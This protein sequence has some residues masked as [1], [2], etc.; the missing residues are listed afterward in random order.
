MNYKNLNFPIFSDRARDQ[1]E[2]DKVRWRE[3]D[4]RTC[5]YAEISYALCFQTAENIYIFL[6]TWLDPPSLRHECLSSH[7]SGRHCG[8]CRWSCTVAS[9]TAPCCV[10][11][12]W[13]L[14]RSTWLLDDTGPPWQRPAGGR[15]PPHYPDP[16]GRNTHYPMYSFTL[17]TFIKSQVYCSSPAQNQSS[18]KSPDKLNQLWLRR[19]TIDWTNECKSAHTMT[20][21]MPQAYIIQGPYTSGHLK[22]KAIQDFSRL[23]EKEIQDCFNNICTFKCSKWS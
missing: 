16:G 14:E 7:L 22:S 11:S 21:I 1:T 6:V 8:C 3:T 9:T 17:Y 20:Y 12:W 5:F 10:H 2:T 15:T 23:F 13:A 4:V 18:V 19:S